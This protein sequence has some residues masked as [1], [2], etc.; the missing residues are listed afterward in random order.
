MPQTV[1]LGIIKTMILK[2]IF[3]L[4]LKTIGTLIVLCIIYFIA[5]FGLSYITCNSDFKQ[6]E[7]DAIEVYI[8]TNGVHTDLVLPL[9]NELRDWT[10]FVNPADTKSGSIEANYVAFGWGD[11]G[12]YLETPTWADLKITI[13]FN[14]LFFLSRS[15]MHV[16]FYKRLNEGESCKKIRIT[17]DSYKNLICYIEGSFEVQENFPLLIKDASYSDNDLLYEAHGTFSLFNTCNT[18]ANSGLKA[19]NLKACLWTPFHQPI[20]SKYE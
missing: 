17:K 8:L 7:K 5:A 16:T 13:A 6:C 1:M 14:A 3:R 19:G 12:F 9:R 4:T 18:W 15:A 2:K 10:T 20:F 11:R